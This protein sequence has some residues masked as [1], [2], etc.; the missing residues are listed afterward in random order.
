MLFLS[1]GVINDIHL[2]LALNTF[3]LNF[4]PWQLV[5]YQFLHAVKDGAGNIIFSHILFNMFALWMF[6]AEIEN[7]WGSKKFLIYYLACGTGAGLLQL[8]LST[9]SLTVGASGSVFG[10]LIAFALMYPDRPI[11]L[12]FLIPIKAKYL[13]GFLVILEFLTVNSG[14]SDGV[15]RFAHLGGALTGFLFILFDKTIHIPLKDRFKSISRPSSFNRKSSSFKSP[16]YTNPAFKR[17]KQKDETD[18][19]DAEFYEIKEDETISQEEIDRILDK[20]SQSGY[21]NLTEREKRILFEA[22]KR[23]K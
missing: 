8:L 13:I 4:Q 7:T 15:A 22:S 16:N 20:I 12:Y 5:T 3:D 6:G 1:R 11:Y 14:S 2:W 17:R 21:K 9:T 18:V 23:M 10:V 19:E